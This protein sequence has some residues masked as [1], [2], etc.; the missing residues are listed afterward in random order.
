MSPSLLGFVVAGD[1]GRVGDGVGEGW[2]RM[3]EG[4]EC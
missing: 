3:V 1:V 2:N 4:L